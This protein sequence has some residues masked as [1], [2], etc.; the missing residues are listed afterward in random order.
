MDTADLGSPPPASYPHHLISLSRKDYDGYLNGLQRADRRCLWPGSLQ[1]DAQ[2][3]IYEHEVIAAK[4]VIDRRP[5]RPCLANACRIAKTHLCL[6]AWET[7]RGRRYDLST[8]AYIL[9]CVLPIP[10]EARPSMAKPS[11]AISWRS[12]DF[13]PHAMLLYR[14]AWGARGCVA[15]SQVVVIVL[16]PQEV[17]TYGSSSPPAGPCL[18]LAELHRNCSHSFWPLDRSRNHQEGCSVRHPPQEPELHLRLRGSV[19]FT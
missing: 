6:I 16:W 18:G 10:D 14:S 3:L 4:R 15:K 17:M 11:D 19:L 13:L 12:G 2:E 8:E 5:R 1:L 7:R 9:R